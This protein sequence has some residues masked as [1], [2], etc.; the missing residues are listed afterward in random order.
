MNATQVELV[1]GS[2]R[3]VAPNA[4]EVGALFY[5]KLFELAPQLRPMF[6]GEV[7]VQQDKLMATL[8]Y[9]VE[10]LDALPTIMRDVQELAARHVGY[11]VRPEHYALVGA[12]LLATLEEGLGADFDARTKQAWEAAYDLLSGA[13]TRSAYL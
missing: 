6:K 1:Q 11:G 13:M 8:R 3:K 12:A 2:F 5:Q 9:V 7:S 10:R 4:S